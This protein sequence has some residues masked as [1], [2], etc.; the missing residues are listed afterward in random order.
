MTLLL[1]SNLRVGYTSF[2]DGGYREV[3]PNSPCLHPGEENQYLDY[4]FTSALIPVFG[5]M[6]LIRL[7]TDSIDSAKWTQ[8]SDGGVRH[9]TPV[10]GYFPN[11]EYLP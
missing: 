5:D 10:P 8:F 1:S 9:T 4:V 3:T 11:S 2:Y 7:R 6:P